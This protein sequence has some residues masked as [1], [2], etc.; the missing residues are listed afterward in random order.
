LLGTGVPV[1][2]CFAVTLPAGV[3]PSIVS[4]K[5]T[6]RLLWQFTGQSTP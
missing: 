4:G 1:E 6:G 5:D 3:D 2:L